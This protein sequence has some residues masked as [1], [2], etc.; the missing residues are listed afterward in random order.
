M[1]AFKTLYRIEFNKKKL[2]IKIIYICLPQQSVK[3][4]D[5]FQMKINK[6]FNVKLYYSILIF[7]TISYISTSFVYCEQT[8]PE[9]YCKQRNNKLNEFDDDEYLLI[10]AEIDSTIVLGCKFW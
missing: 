6:I 4:F 5:F 7:V 9:K 3:H 10:D 2:T 1:L 8:K